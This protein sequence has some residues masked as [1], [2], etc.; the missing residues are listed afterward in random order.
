MLTCTAASTFQPGKLAHSAARERVERTPAEGNGF[1]GRARQKRSG[2]VGMHDVR[3][4]AST[5]P[6]ETCQE[7]LFQAD[8]DVPC[9]GA[10]DAPRIDAPRIDAPPSAK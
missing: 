1:A 10:I 8:G 3:G 5:I 4:Q 7:L 9:P 2:G 6:C